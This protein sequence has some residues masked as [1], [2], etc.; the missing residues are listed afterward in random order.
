[1]WTT[2]SVVMTT[3]RRTFSLSVTGTTPARRQPRQPK[4]DDRDPA[5]AAHASP[6]LGRSELTPLGEDP[7]PGGLPTPKW[8]SAS[9]FVRA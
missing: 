9:L 8:H 4:H 7:L 2:S 5:H 3:E 1:M 6:I